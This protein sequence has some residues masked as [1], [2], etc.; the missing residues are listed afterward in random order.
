MNYFKNFVFACGVLGVSCSSSLASSQGMPQSQQS[1]QLK[2]SSEQEGLQ[3]FKF[4]QGRWKQDCNFYFNQR[5][6]PVFSE[7]H[8]IAD[9]SDDGKIF[10]VKWDYAASNSKNKQSLGQY[11][12]NSLYLI[13]AHNFQKYG[14]LN[15]RP[16]KTLSS[17][18]VSQVKSDQFRVLEKSQQGNLVSD[19]LFTI[20]SPKHIRSD[21][22]LKGDLQGKHPDWRSEIQ[23]ELYAI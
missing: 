21:Q 1:M 9:L 12:T 11:V 13:H 15:Q 8:A 16:R 3:L 20:I 5:K 2:Q 19:E 7:G 22:K 10:F 14:F 23:C 4:L 6:N 18:V 17:G